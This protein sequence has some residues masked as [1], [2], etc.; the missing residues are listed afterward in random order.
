MCGDYHPCGNSC[1]HRHLQAILEVP[2]SSALLDGGTQGRSRRNQLQQRT[3]GRAGGH[4][5]QRGGG[6]GIPEH[7]AGESQ[8]PTLRKTQR[9]HMILLSIP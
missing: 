9:K 8:Q 2:H 5:S 4:Y 6:G 7:E 3:R 1:W